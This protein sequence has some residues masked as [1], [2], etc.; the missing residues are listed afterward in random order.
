[1]PAFGRSSRRSPAS[2]QPLRIFLSPT[3]VLLIQQ[4]ADS[5]SPLSNGNIDAKREENMEQ[6]RNEVTPERFAEL[7][8]LVQRQVAGQI[9]DTKATAHA[10]L[11]RGGG[12]GRKGRGRG[13]R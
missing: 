9:E 10:R 8:Q 11:N 12:A 5:Q 3:A 7:Q 4:A 13:R 1:M 6:L 2:K